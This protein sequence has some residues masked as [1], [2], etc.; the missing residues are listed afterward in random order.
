M[1]SIRNDTP[2]TDEKGTQCSLICSSD[3]DQYNATIS[4]DV[5][6]LS[7]GPTV[8]YKLDPEATREILLGNSNHIDRLEYLTRISTCT[9]NQMSPNK[10]TF[11]TDTQNDEH[12]TEI[13]I[14]AQMEQ[15]L[16]QIETP[17]EAKRRRLRTVSPQ[18]YQEN[19]MG[20]DNFQ[21]LFTYGIGG[22]V[23]NYIIRQ[24]LRL[25]SRYH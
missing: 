13:S 24:R 17:R 8:V 22:V 2:S 5:C 18:T 19:K 4:G 1:P 7:I 16:N 14:F 10:I 20:N 3:C 15:I 23:F 11:C 12:I 9:C 21:T 6:N 25:V